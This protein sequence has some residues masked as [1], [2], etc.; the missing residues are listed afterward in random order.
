MHLGVDFTSLQKGP[1]LSCRSDDGGG[2][3][4]SKISHRHSI[5][6]RSDDL[7]PLHVIYMIFI[8]IHSL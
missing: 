7:R 4:C 5:G 8:L 6:L 1:S 2:E 3:S